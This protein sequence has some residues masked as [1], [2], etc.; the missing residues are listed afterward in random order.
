MFLMIQRK[1][2]ETKLIKNKI[3]YKQDQGI[4]LTTNE[5]KYIEVWMAE[6]KESNILNVRD[7]MMPVTHS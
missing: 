1:R 6:V 3:I 4:K 2:A 7:S 5:K